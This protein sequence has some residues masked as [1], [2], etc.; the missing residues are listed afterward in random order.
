MSEPDPPTRDQVLYEKS[1]YLRVY[2][3]TLLQE[4]K[5]LRKTSSELRNANAALAYDLKLIRAVG[6]FPNRTRQDYLHDVASD[7][8]VD[9]H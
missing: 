3:T 6:Y 4:A 5:E 7:E 8:N 1:V 2:S 9:N